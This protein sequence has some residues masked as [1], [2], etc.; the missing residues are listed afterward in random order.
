M[1][2]YT[3]HDRGRI[4]CNSHI[5]LLV[6]ARFHPIVGI[7]VCDVPVAVFTPSLHVWGKENDNIEQ[8]MAPAV[9]TAITTIFEPDLFNV[10]GRLIF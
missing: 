2:N 8:C 1:I 6:H 5:D 10:S 4:L 9:Y 3:I 7:A